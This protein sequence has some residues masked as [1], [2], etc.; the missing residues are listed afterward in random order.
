MRVLIDD[1]VWIGFD[2]GYIAWAIAEGAVVCAGTVV[3]NDV[4]PYSIVVS[5]PQKI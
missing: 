4:P 1:F 3:I 2:Q 5:V